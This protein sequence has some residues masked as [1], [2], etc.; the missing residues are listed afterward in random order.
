[1][2]SLHRIKK[3]VMGA[4]VDKCY[5]RCKPIYSHFWIDIHSSRSLTVTFLFFCWR[6]LTA[7]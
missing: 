3:L 1:M 6:F 4:A 2:I 5:S 7:I